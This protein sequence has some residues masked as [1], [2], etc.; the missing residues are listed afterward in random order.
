MTTLHFPTPP[1]AFR[2]SPIWN[3]D[4][5]RLTQMLND[6][7]RVPGPYSMAHAVALANE[8]RERGLAVV[9][10]DFPLATLDRTPSSN[11]YRVGL[12][13]VAPRSPRVI[14]IRPGLR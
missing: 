2:V 8:I 4:R 7:G 3:T 6:A 10:R 9:I 11:I 13:P 14:K 1:G 12:Q 5:K